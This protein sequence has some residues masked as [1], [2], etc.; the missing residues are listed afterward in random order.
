MVSKKFGQGSE[1]QNPKIKKQQ[2]QSPKSKLDFL[3]NE[4]DS[5]SPIEPYETKIQTKWHWANGLNFVS[6]SP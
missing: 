5:C 6:P 2:I 1:L 3:Q 4:H